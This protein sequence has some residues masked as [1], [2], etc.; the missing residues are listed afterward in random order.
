M[1]A[2]LPASN[3]TPAPVGDQPAPV[4]EVSGLA[5]RFGATLAVDGIDFTVG[6]GA[7]V[8]LL[9]ATAR[10]RPPPSLLAL[11]VPSGGSIRVLG[12][13][14]ARDRFAAL[15]RM[16]FSSPYVVLPSRLSVA[17]NLRVYGYLYGV[18]R[19]GQLD[20]HDLLRRSAGALSADRRPGSRWPSR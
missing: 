3:G 11:L 16:N 10:A 19:I 17:G 2:R 12:H 6:R 20:L 15:T 18:Q 13:D 4:I 8:G 1:T 7:A 9:A 5:K 14:M